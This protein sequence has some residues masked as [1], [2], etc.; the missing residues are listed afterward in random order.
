[1]ATKPI[2]ANKARNQFPAAGFWMGCSHAVSHTRL[3]LLHA[4]VGTL[5]AR[6]KR[7]ERAPAGR[8]RKD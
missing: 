6:M 5:L 2:L 7:T 8:L 3:S 4:L 1:M